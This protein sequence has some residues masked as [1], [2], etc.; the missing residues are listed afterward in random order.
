M[1]TRFSDVL[2]RFGSIVCDLSPRIY[3]LNIIQHHQSLR[4]QLK[5][6]TNNPLSSQDDL[7]QGL[8]VDNTQQ[9]VGC[10]PCCG[11]P[12]GRYF[13]AT[14]IAIVGIVVITA[15]PKT[16]P[17]NFSETNCY[18]V[19]SATDVDEYPC[20]NGNECASKMPSIG[21]IVGGVALIILA[22]VFSIVTCCHQGRCILSNRTYDDKVCMCC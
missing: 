9:D 5:M 14:V 20:R 10:R 12:I 7:R 22:L 17:P 8:T 11:L 15:T 21:A 2:M 13:V 4:W 3:H 19:N 1:E 6:I 16:C 18:V